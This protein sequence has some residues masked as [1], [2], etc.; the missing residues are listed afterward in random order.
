M[1]IKKSRNE[2]NVYSMQ[3]ALRVYKFNSSFNKKLSTYEALDQCGSSIF[4]RSIVFSEEFL[5]IN[6]LVLVIFHKGP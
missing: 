5:L 4:F 6:I 1:R 2:Y 3:T